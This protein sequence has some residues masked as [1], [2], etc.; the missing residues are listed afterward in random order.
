MSKDI[1]KYQF[2]QEQLD[3]LRLSFNGIDSDKN[4]YL[5]KQEISQFMQA[6][7]LDPRFVEAI[8]KLF[9]KN[10]DGELCF[11]EFLEY[12]DAC[13]KSAI[14]PTYLFKMIFEAIDVDHDG[15]LDAAEMVEFGKLT[16]FPMTLE[17]AQE[18]IK[19]LDNDGNGKLDF[20]ELLKAF[21]F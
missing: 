9:D 17:Q 15:S 19:V 8:F 16:G 10:Q 12:I 21:G 5:S 4:G 7:Q 20:Q 11:D 18:D 2:T 6:N 14:D 1:P 3:A 13:N